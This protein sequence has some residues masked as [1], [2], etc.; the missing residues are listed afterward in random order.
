MAL[1]AGRLAT[2]AGHPLNAEREE[3]RARQCKQG[4]RIGKPAG[5]SS[6][7]PWDRR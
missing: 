4:E 6:W 2:R 1:V 7:L 5:D 3:R